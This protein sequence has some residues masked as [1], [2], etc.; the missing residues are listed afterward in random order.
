[1]KTVNSNS[2]GR[3]QYINYENR[4][5]KE[6]RFYPI[7]KCFTFYVYNVKNIYVLSFSNASTV[8]LKAS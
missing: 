1:M 3:F 4:R 5:N 8:V 2:K 7:N 6:D